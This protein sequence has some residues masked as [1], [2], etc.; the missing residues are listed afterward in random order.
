MQHR[1][2]LGLE[3]PERGWERPLVLS[4]PLTDPSAAPRHEAVHADSEQGQEK[5]DHRAQGPSGRCVPP[6][7]RIPY[8]CSRLL[9]QQLLPQVGVPKQHTP[10]LGSR[11]FA[12]APGCSTLTCSACDILSKGMETGF[13]PLETKKHRSIS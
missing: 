12:A 6:P 11:G 4:H 8:T 1:N 7:L 9:D 13:M 3:H 2:A 5:G 10:F